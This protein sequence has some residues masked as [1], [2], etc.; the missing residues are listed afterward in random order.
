MHSS[1]AVEQRLCEIQIVG[2]LFVV[3]GEDKEGGCD[4]R[5]NNG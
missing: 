5:V 3:S 4:T 2:N 1:S